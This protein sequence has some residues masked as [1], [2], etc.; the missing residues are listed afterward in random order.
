MKIVWISKIEGHMPHK[1]SRLKLTEALIK[2]GHDVILTMAGKFGEKKTLS[3]N[4]VLIPTIS[5]PVLSGFLYGLIVFFYFPILLN[6]KNVDVI[7]IDCTKI[8]LP[9]VISLKIL[10]KPIVLD[11]RTLP[12]DKDESFS[13]KV[14]MFLSR[15]VVDGISTITPDLMNVLIEKYNLNDIKIGI[16]SSGVS[17]EDFTNV[18]LEKKNNII[19]EIN[20]SQFVLIYHGDYS[21]TRGIE[22]IIKSLNKLDPN[23]K[24]KIK[25]LIVG[26]PEDK[27][28]NLYKLSYAEGVEDKVIILPKVSYDQIAQFIKLSDVGVIPLPP[29]NKWWRV[30]APLKTLEYLASSK[31]VIA[32]NIPFHS[33]IFKEEKCGKLIKSGSP[34]VIAEGINWMYK[35]KEDLKKMGENGR[36]IAEKMYT[37]DAMAEKLEILL[38]N[39]IDKS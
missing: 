12:I 28:K 3:K 24:K 7:I 4:I 39:I 38:D 29:E 2:R 20:G 8:W 16:W 26:M 10:N 30:S 1:T 11:I 9:F 6:R 32:T 17:I 13:F 31:P 35:N 21:P 27:V 37:W 25:L 14:S 23:L 5:L 33:N 19:N 34:Q 22:N 18:K 15:F 36:K